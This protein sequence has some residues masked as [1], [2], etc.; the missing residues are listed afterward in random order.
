MIIIGTEEQVKLLPIQAI[1]LAAL[2]VVLNGEIAYVHKNKFGDMG[3][4]TF[5]E[6][7]DLLNKSFED[8]GFQEETESEVI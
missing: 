2:V 1:E 6:L 4:V 8:M 5:D 3:A 7:V